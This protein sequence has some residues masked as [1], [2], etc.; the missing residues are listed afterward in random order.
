MYTRPSWFCDNKDQHAKRARYKASQMLPLHSGYSTGQTSRHFNGDLPIA[1]PSSLQGLRHSTVNLT[2]LESRHLTRSFFYKG[3]GKPI[4]YIFLIFCHTSPAKSNAV[5]P[6]RRLMSGIWEPRNMS[7]LTPGPSLHIHTST[8]QPT[9][10]P[11]I[12]IVGCLSQNV[13][14]FQG[15]TP[16][17]SSLEKYFHYSKPGPERTEF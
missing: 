8:W 12:L 3:P 9:P 13:F 7:R 11:L 6:S 14:A 1:L 17:K 5:N 10:H 2:P 16:R 4:S 15:I